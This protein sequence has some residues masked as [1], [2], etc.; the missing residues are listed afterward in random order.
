MGAVETRPN[1][2]FFGDNL[3]VLRDHIADESVDLIYLDPPFNSNATYNVLFKAPDGH[4]SQAQITAFEDTWHWNDSAEDAYWQVLKGGNSDAAKM[5]EAM[6]GFLGENDMMAYLAMMAIRLIELHRVLK[7][8]GSLYLHCDPTASHYLKVLLDAV[9]GATNFKN[10][11]IWRRTGS[12]NS[13]KR[14]GPIHDTI[15]FY[16]RSEA[17]KF[18]R[19][20]RPY[21]R[22]HVEKA[23]VKEGDRFRTNYSGNVL[24]GSGTRNGLSG[25]P[26]RG[27]D[28]TAK[29]R[30]W[31][32][33]SKLLFGI[34]EQFEGLDQHE[35]FDRLFEMGAIT[36]K[37]GDEWPRYQRYLNDTD[38]QFLSDIW[39]YQPY[40][41]G[42]VFG[43]NEGVDDD[44]RWMGSKDGDRLGYPTQ[45][46]VALLER[47]IS[48]SSNPGD[49]VLDPFCGCGTTIHAAQKLGRRW[50]GIDITPLAVNLIKRR[51]SEA[52]GA[53]ADFSIV[54]LPQ[55]LDGAQA[56]FAQDPHLFQLWAVSLIPDAQPWKGGK[57]GA[58]TGIDG[59]LY[60]RTG[61]ADTHRAMI[62]VKGGKHVG[63][64]MVRDFAHV[65]D[66][67]KALQG[68]FISLTK[69]T[70]DMET[71][72][73]KAGYAETDHGRFRKL[74]IMTIE[75]LLAGARP[76]M[77]F[78][79]TAAF[80]KTRRETSTGHQ[81][82]MDF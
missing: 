80:R 46:P 43:T 16:A 47:I 69:P 23:F 22:G 28:P 31:A 9:F 49:I 60:L 27:F 53:A 14:F 37:E 35:S 18:F 8:T 36:I 54:G 11:I 13:T 52:F 62:S 1:K 56:L 10:E 74:Q 78:V 21:M 19:H 32:L 2:L 26:W 50:M 75:S 51:L 65:I 41:E 29:G 55:D 81:G 64:S 25:R 5:M 34:E 42:T 40:T 4:Q 7:P 38:G 72:A 70:R 61:K 76:E 48:A 58:D 82:E 44:V 15:L 45:K 20:T 79:D 3:R 71:E 24:T 33:P 73:V 17:S 30:H 66:R 39:A 77:P 12:H 68:I 57:K 63:V 6:R 67:E 59:Q